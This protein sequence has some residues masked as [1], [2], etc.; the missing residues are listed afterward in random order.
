MGKDCLQLD[1]LINQVHTF[2]IYKKT[3]LDTDQVSVL[4]SSLFLLQIDFP[5]S[6]F[7]IKFTSPP[8]A[9]FSPKYNFSSLFEGDQRKL[10]EV[11]Q[12]ESLYWWEDGFWSMSIQA[13]DERQSEIFI[14]L[15]KPDDLREGRL[16]GKLPLQHKSWLL[17]QKHPFSAQKEVAKQVLSTFLCKKWLQMPF[18]FAS[19]KTQVP[20]NF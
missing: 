11:M 3:F 19:K 17:T 8:A 6:S 13:V 18:V 16:S 15:S 5:S 1:C 14:F 7:E 20:S 10:K 4:F 2:L 12:K 9:D